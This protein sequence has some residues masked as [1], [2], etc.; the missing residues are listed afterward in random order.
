MCVKGKRINRGVGYGLEIPTEYILWQVESYSMGKVNI[1]WYRW[2]NE[3][4]R[5][6]KKSH[7]EKISYLC[8]LFLA[9]PLLG[10]N[11]LRYNPNRT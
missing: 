2:E 9:C 8:F 4:K 11:F 7:F 10:G 6:L 5:C 3:K 1:R